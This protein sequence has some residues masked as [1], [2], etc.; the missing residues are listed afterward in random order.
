MEVMR[1]YLIMEPCSICGLMELCR[2]RLP[3]RW[4]PP[5][6]GFVHLPPESSALL[7]NAIFVWQDPFCT[8]RKI[9]MSAVELKKGK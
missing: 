4:R 5:T 8:L 6:P 7:S 9:A 1:A 2:M 3:W